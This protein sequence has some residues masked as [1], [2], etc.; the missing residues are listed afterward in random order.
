MRATIGLIL[1]AMLAFSIVAPWASIWVDAAY[2]E[3]AKE[4]FHLVTTP[5]IGLIGAAFGFYFGERA[6]LDEDD[7]RRRLD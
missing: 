3:S 5:L 2:M 1:L 4:L 6:V 7:H